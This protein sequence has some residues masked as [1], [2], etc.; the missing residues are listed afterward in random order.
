MFGFFTNERYIAEVEVSAPEAGAGPDTG[1][2]LKS[3]APRDERPAASLDD[4]MRELA[5]LL[6]A[7]QEPSSVGLYGRPVAAAATTAGS[8]ATAG[9][10]TSATPA[11]S[12]AARPARASGRAGGPVS[13]PGPARVGGATAAA[14]A[15]KAAPAQRAAKPLTPAKHTLMLPPE[16]L[17]RGPAEP[18]ADKPAGPS[19]FAA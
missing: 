5:D 9:T 18:V 14:A 8:A 2:V 19:P 1:S 4:R 17:H 13:T 16:E 11:A 6:G 10:A 12:A 15:R 3:A 7:P